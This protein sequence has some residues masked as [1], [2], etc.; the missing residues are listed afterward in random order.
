MKNNKK[1]L[2]TEKELKMEII[3][4]IYIYITQNTGAQGYVD[5]L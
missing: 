5:T 1:I 3:K 4:T 2:V